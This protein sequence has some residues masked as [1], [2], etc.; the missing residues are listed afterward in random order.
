MN[1]RRAAATIAFLLFSVS[2]CATDDGRT[3]REPT[4]EQIAQVV[5]SSSSTSDASFD[6]VNDG[7][8]FRVEG[9]WSEGAR[10][11][12]RYTCTGKNVSPTLQFSSIPTG[13]TTIAVT[14]TDADSPGF[15]HWV[16]VNMDPAAMLKEGVTPPGALVI[17][18]S[19]G[20][21][22]YYGPCPPKGQ[23]HTYILTAYALG[24]QVEVVRN[25]D[26]VDVIS[27]LDELASDLTSTTFTFS[28]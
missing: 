2:A 3:M 23:Q 7:A 27:M 25:D 22:D 9:P 17:K 13:T 21:Y 4:P 20:R 8:L 10:I 26:A 28:R 1:R 5:P 15:V 6:T 14:L 16:M 12:K 19:A 11:D 18:N 24:Q